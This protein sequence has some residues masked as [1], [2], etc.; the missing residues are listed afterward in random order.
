MKDVRP[1]KNGELPGRKHA[2]MFAGASLACFLPVL[3]EAHSSTRDL[4]LA[5]TWE[6]KVATIVEMDAPR[7][8]RRGAHFP[9]RLRVDDHG[10]DWLVRWAER[11]L[12]VPSL[13]RSWSE[14]AH[15]PA[16]GDRI[17]AVGDRIDVYVAPDP[18][19]QIMP[20]SALWSEFWSGIYIALMF[21]AF[22]GFFL[23]LA[24]KA[25]RGARQ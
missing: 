17:P 5:R 21:V 15:F 4:I 6:A 19:F 22:G 9:V 1:P 20:A 13:R 2:L 18:P 25:W 23:W 7:F 12:T 8:N 24:A 14:P 11:D 16:V 3:L 10:G